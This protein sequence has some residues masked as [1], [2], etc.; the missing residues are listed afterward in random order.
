M[1]DDVTSIDWDSLPL[2]QKTDASIALELGV[3]PSL[4]RSARVVRGIPGLPRSAWKRGKRQAPGGEAGRSVN[5]DSLP[6]GQKSDSEIARDLGVKGD[7]I[8]HQRRIRGIPAFSRNLEAQAAARAAQG[9]ATGEDRIAFLEAEVARLQARLRNLSKS[10]KKAGEGD[11]PV[12]LDSAARDALRKVVEVWHRIADLFNDASVLCWPAAAVRRP[13]GRVPGDLFA[14]IGASFR[15]DCCEVYFP[16]AEVFRLEAG[17]SWTKIRV[18]FPILSPAF[19]VVQAVIVPGS[20]QPSWRVES[21]DDMNGVPSVLWLY[22]DNTEAEDD[23]IKTIRARIFHLQRNAFGDLEPLFST[24]AWFHP[25]SPKV[26]LDRWCIWWEDGCLMARCC[27]PVLHRDH[28]VAMT[29]K[30]SFARN[31]V[32]PNSLRI[33][34]DT[35]SS[36]DDPSL[37]AHRNNR[38]ELVRD[39]D[40]ERKPLMEEIV[41]LADRVFEDAQKRGSIASQLHQF[42]FASRGRLA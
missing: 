1:V 14:E 19:A 12:L 26:V 9:P 29:V 30:A 35:V 18:Q 16:V 31:S 11:P 5:W 36:G 27:F 4:V 7:C 42:V 23:L 6:Y 25:S 39:L 32:A 41:K 8:A 21:G 2:G 40:R 3:P 15:N 24:L 33:F 17:R 37:F 34:L 10:A 20:D 38:I 28:Q 13:P 22:K